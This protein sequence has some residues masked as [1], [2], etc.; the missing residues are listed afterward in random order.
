MMMDQG[1]AFNEESV[2]PGQ[3]KYG[4]LLLTVRTSMSN[5]L[6][7]ENMGSLVTQRQSAQ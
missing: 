7:D 2:L 6:D 3:Q 1:C 5:L 4:S